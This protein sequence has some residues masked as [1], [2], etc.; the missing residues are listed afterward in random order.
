MRHNISQSLTKVSLSSGPLPWQQVGW[1]QLTALQGDNEA[2]SNAVL[3]TGQEGVGKFH[4]AIEWIKYLSCQQPK[5]PFQKNKETEL[6]HGCQICPHCVQIQTQSYP[7]LWCVAKEPT[8]KTIKIDQI[9]AVI[10]GVQLAFNGWRFVIIYQAHEMTLAAQNAL[11]KNLEEPGEQTLYILI[12]SQPSGL[13]ATVRSRCQRFHFGG[14]D[15]SQFN[16][17]WE[18]QLIATGLSSRYQ[19]LESSSNH[20]LHVAKQSPLK[21]WQLFCLSVEAEHEGA[22]SDHVEP[23]MSMLVRN[24]WCQKWSRLQARSVTVGEMVDLAVSHDAKQGLMFMMSCIVDLLKLEL[25]SFGTLDR[26]AINEIVTNLDVMDWLVKIKQ[27][28]IVQVYLISCYQQLLE[29]WRLFDNGQVLNE[30]LWWETFFLDW[31]LQNRD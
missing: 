18:K 6:R 1:A 12:S 2:H 25:L 14:V 3:L 19:A 22:I 30:R 10:E 4:F 16:T 31:L 29:N 9:R 24:E 13:L 28:G 21:A 8:A 26:S 15:K 23:P 7:G 11:L 27:Q 20:Y 5:E 17:W